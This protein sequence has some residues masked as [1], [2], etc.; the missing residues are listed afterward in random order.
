METVPLSELTCRVEKFQ[1]LLA[2]ADITLALLRQPADLF[3]CTGT[4][5]EES[6]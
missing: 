6:R 3:Y 5:V 4:S 1:A 2:E